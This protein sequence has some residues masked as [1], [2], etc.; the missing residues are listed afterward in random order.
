MKKFFIL[1]QISNFNLDIF[2]WV[3]YYILNLKERDDISKEFFL[4][5]YFT[6]VFIVV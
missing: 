6:N 4:V 2:I 5:V 3:D 1:N